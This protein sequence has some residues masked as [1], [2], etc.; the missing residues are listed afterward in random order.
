M[1]ARF[2][3]LTLLFICAASP[4]YAARFS[5]DY[6]LY[7]CDSDKDGKE[8]TPGGHIACQAYIAGVIDYHNLVRSLGTAPSVDF[9]IPESVDMNVLQEQVRAYILRHRYQHGKFVAAPGVALALYE[10][11][12]CG[13]RK[14]K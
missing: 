12:P 14:R 7:V 2:F 3:L 9:C 4:A 1:A 5:G 8:T 6:L 11:Y 10:N 13:K